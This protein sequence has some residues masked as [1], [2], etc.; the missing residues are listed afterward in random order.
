MGPPNGPANDLVYAPRA[1]EILL[2]AR[3]NHHPVVV[4]QELLYV[5]SGGLEGLAT[6]QARYR[7]QGFNL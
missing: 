2:G 6:M 5:H 7:R 1:W 3:S 4:G